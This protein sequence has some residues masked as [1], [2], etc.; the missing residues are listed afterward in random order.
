MRK[1]RVVF[2]A[3]VSAGVAFAALTIVTAS[4]A[5]AATAAFSIVSSWGNGYQ[6]NFTVT[7][8]SSAPITS[9]RVEFD[10]PPGSTIGNSWNTQQT[11]SGNH[12]TFTNAPYNGSL[13]AGAATSFGFIVNG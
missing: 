2:A 9:W 5:S 4:S 3:A 12:Y 13:A 11:T 8:N 6:G 7:N 10:L 1:L